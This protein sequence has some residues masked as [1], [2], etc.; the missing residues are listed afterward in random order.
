MNTPG[1][2]LS[3]ALTTSRDAANRIASL[4]SRRP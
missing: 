2:Q 3:F 4:D 1:K